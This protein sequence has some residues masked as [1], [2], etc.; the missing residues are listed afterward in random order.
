MRLGLLYRRFRP[1]T[2]ILFFLAFDGGSADTRCQAIVTASPT[3]SGSALFRS[4]IVDPPRP[5]APAA[6]MNIFGAR[7]MKSAC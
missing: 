3:S 1:F 2:A 4:I 5:H 6:G 7:D